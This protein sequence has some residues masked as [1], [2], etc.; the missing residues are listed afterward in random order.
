MLK[1]ASFLFTIIILILTIISLTIILII[2]IIILCPDCSCPSLTP[3]S[4]FPLP[5]LSPDS[6][7]LGKE[8]AFHGHQPPL[9]PLVGFPTFFYVYQ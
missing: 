2:L 6:P 7:R 9:S 1:S 5:P 8:Q 4:F 3:C